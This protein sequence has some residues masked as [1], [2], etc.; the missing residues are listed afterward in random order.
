MGAS[1]EEG[2]AKKGR[3]VPWMQEFL[4]G[5]SRDTVLSALSLLALAW[6]DLAV[7]RVTGLAQLQL[8]Q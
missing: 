3:I 6:A 7:W 8:V 5:R 1:D 4:R 2:A